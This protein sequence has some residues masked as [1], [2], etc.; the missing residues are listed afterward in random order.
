MGNTSLKPRALAIRVRDP[1]LSSRMEVSGL[2]MSMASGT[3]GALV[4]GPQ[5]LD[6]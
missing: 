1:C 6:V 5:T 4:S 3:E 2:L